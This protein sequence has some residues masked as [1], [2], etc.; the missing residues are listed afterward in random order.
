MVRLTNIPQDSLLLSPIAEV[1][2]GHKSCQPMNG[3]ISGIHCAH[4]TL[5]VSFAVCLSSCH[6]IKTSH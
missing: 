2:G 1:V 3:N 6:D 4:S 5:M